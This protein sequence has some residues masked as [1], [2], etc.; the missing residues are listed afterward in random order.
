MIFNTVV[1]GGNAIEIIPQNIISPAQT[2]L[3]ESGGYVFRFEY[4]QMSI[5]Y[6]I[7]LYVGDS[8][9]PTFDVLPP[10][11]HSST[12]L[13]DHMGY[14]NGGMRIITLDHDVYAI[15]IETGGGDEN[16]TYAIVTPD[17]PIISG[18]NDTW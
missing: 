15:E 4:I 5:N 6:T 2:S 13:S 17:F 11:N 10:T 3:T 18:W 1:G 14:D 16:V 7:F 8:F 9:M 12:L